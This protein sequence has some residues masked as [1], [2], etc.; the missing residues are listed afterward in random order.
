MSGKFLLPF[1]LPQK[2]TGKLRV[3]HLY[4]LTL[5]PEANKCNILHDNYLELL[6]TTHTLRPPLGQ[7]QCPL[8]S[9]SCFLFNLGLLTG[10]QLF[11]QTF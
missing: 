7:G 10:T 1:L 9:S 4:F 8:S 6:R 3:H 2:T 5:K 11:S